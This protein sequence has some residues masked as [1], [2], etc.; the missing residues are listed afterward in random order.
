MSRRP[1]GLVSTSW[2]PSSRV[3]MKAK[4]AFF[5]NKKP[6]TAGRVRPVRHLMDRH[7]WPALGFIE[8]CLP[9]SS[10]RPRSGPEW[11]HEIKFDGYRL[12]VW[13]EG[14]RVRLFTRGGYTG[15]IETRT[16][17]RLRAGLGRDHS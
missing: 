13:R 5:E 14:N 17:L 1:H 3:A 8:P 6:K 7:Y 10:N 2:E 11:V 12:M 16:L 9:S 4:P 15:P